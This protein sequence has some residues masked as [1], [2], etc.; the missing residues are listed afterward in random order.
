MQRRTFLFSGITTGLA[1]TSPASAGRLL[2]A[3]ASAPSETA[4]DAGFTNPPLIAKPHTLWHWMNGVVT[5]GG[6]TADLESFK[7]AGLGGVQLFLVGGSEAKIDE[8]TNQILSD[9]WKSLFKHAVE[10]CARLGLQFGTHNSPGWSSTGFK[11]IDLKDSMQTV[12][13]AETK[14]AGGATFNGV[15]KQP[16]SYQGWYRDIVCWAVPDETVVSLE[17]AIDLS[18]QLRPDGSLTWTAPPGNWAIVRIGHT[19]LGKTNGT[20]PLSGQGNEVDKLDPAPLKAYWETFPTELL[21]LAGPHVGKTF[22]HFEIDSFEMGYQNWTGILPA[23]FRRRRGYDMLPMLLV[24][25]GRTIESKDVSTRFQYDWKATAHEMFIENYFQTMQSLIHRAPGMKLLLEPYSTGKEQPF[26]TVNAGIAADLPMAE[27]WQKPTPWGWDTNKGVVSG[28]HVWD[29]NVIA[30]EAFTGQPNSAW[31]VDPYALK[32][33]GDRAFADGINKFYFHTS[34]HQPWKTVLPGMTMGQ[35]GTHFGRTQ[36]WWE[37]GGP[38]WIRYLAR[39]QFL[40]QHGKPVA[41][42]LYLVYSRVTPKP[43]PGFYSETI[44]TD[45]LLTRLRVKDGLLT[46]PNGLS[47]KVLV[48]PKTGTMRVDVAAKLRELVEAGAKVVGPPPTTSPGLA[49][50]ERA[51]ALVASVG[52]ALWSAKYASQVLDQPIDEAIKTFGLEPDL[53][54]VSTDL[55]SPLLWIHRQSPTEDIYFVSNQ[56]DLA[57]KAEISVPDLGRVPELWDADT[58]HREEAPYHFVQ[59]KRRHVRLDL[60]PSGSAFIVL[61]R[62]AVREATVRSLI[63]PSDDGFSTILDGQLLAA[64]NGNFTILLANGASRRIAVSDIAAPFKIVTPWRL[65][66]ANSETGTSRTLSALVSWTEFEDD[67]RYYS[68]TANYRTEFLFPRRLASDSV[69]ALDLGAVQNIAR[70]RLN[71]R[72]LGTLWKPP[73]RLD[74]TSALRIGRNVLEVEVTNLWANR[75]IGDERFPDDLQ[76]TGKSLKSLPDWIDTDKARPETRRKTFATYKFF[77]GK[78]ALLPSGLMGPV[79]IRQLRR[80]PFG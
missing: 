47:Y 35:W 68:G 12:V 36:T 72:E 21:E 57:G 32:S 74:L 29:K 46:L 18:S 69:Y 25:S 7:R 76:W 6:I 44:G 34:A 28:A 51:D 64:Q 71:G 45:A 38:E 19:S 39:S 10:E 3:R 8:P 20:A 27:F 54:V 16:D 40:L 37:H 23:E 60:P 77:D 75:M 42:L 26:E 14:L 30:A 62:S 73:F 31:R 79:M 65:E 61:R 2:A 56:T 17:K 53:E 59:G 67:T 24:V 48:L 11:T 13:F 5:R 4:L 55:R 49:D 52:A 41:D 1:L 50:R 80:R 58:S 43:V 66:F 9:K 33:T 15:L 22:V 70:V 78:E 63:A